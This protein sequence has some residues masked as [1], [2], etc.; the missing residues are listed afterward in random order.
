MYESHAISDSAVRK[1]KR[2]FKEGRASVRDLPRAGRPKSWPQTATPPKGGDGNGQSYF[3]QETSRPS[4]HKQQ[5][6]PHP[7]NHDHLKMRGDITLGAETAYGRAKSRQSQHIVKVSSAVSRPMRS[8]PGPHR[9]KCTFPTRPT[10]H[11]VTTGC[12]QT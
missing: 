6:W 1:W 8:F 2:D 4:Q 9:D 5:F 7:S 11:P 3:H 12:S 10:W